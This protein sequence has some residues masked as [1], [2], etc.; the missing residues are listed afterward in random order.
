[1]YLFIYFKSDILFFYFFVLGTV[2]YSVT[3]VVTGLDGKFII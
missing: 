3:I 1:M 2:I